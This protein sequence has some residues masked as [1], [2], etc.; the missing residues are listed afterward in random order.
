MN[1]GVTEIAIA[2]LAFLIIRQIYSKWK[3]SPNN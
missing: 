3:K 1:I 2:I